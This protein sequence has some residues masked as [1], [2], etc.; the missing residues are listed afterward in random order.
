MS[1]PGK[2]YGQS[3]NLLG[4]IEVIS[5]L[6]G[7]ASRGCYSLIEISRHLSLFLFQLYWGSLMISSAAEP[8][9]GNAGKVGQHTFV[10]TC[11][12]LAVTFEELHIQVGYIYGRYPAL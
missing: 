9:G 10:A 1:E 2:L 8:Q 5:Q 7:N 6:I 3:K 11:S 4:N 12:M